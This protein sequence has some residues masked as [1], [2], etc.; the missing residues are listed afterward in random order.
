MRN[1]DYESYDAVGLA[2]LVRTKQISELELL[3]HVIERIDKLNPVLNAVS[4]RF[5]DKARDQIQR[6]TPDGPFKGVPFLLKDISAEYKGTPFS[7]GCGLYADNISTFNSTVVEKYLQSGLVILGKTTTSE[8][9]LVGHV[10]TKLHGATRNPWALDRST[11]GSSGGSAAVIAARILPA[12]HGSD[13]GGSIRIP[14]SWSGIFGLKTT[15]GRI[16]YGPNNGEGIGGF[17]ASGNLSISVRDS[18]ALLDVIAGDDPGGSYRIPA[19][20]RPY[21][22]EI[23]AP[24]GRLRI[25]VITDLQ[26]LTLAPEAKQ[27]TEHAARLCEALGHHVEIVRL[28]INPRELRE[29]YKIITA[30]NMHSK[31]TSYERQH[32]RR[33]QEH[34]I[35]PYTWASY[36]AGADVS[37]TELLET[38]AKIQAITRQLAPW[39]IEYDV[40]V[41]PTT[42]RLPLRMD[43]LENLGHDLSSIHELLLHCFPMTQLFNM[44]GY[45]AM[46]VPLYWTKENLPMGTQF[47]AGIGKESLLFRLAAQLEEAQ[48]WASRRPTYQATENFANLSSC[49]AR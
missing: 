32:Q 21:L 35:E 9:G 31:I 1:F 28:P 12:A 11:G 3:E 4:Y 23:G 34:E 8:L 10:N 18:A 42:G 15:R 24:T 2:F 6:G 25:G 29:I 20:E 30:V 41:T 33:V 5:Y 40:L 37:G 46:S 22:E 39:F 26:D 19:P 44:I 36:Q 48:P 14:A 49:D 16:P 38:M 47:S 13:G 17:A 27:A 45:P 43:E 7:Q